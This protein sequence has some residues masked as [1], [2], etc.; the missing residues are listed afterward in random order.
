MEMVKGNKK[1]III[2]CVIFLVFVGVYGYNE[3]IKYRNEKI[4]QDVI[5]SNETV[6]EGLYSD[7]ENADGHDSRID[8]L[9]KAISTRDEYIKNSKTDEDED[10]TAENKYY[11]EVTDG[12]NAYIVEMQDYLISEYTTTIENNT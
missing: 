6:A 11:E 12:Y 4:R 10:V 3:Y 1:R 8:I 2:I 5:S 9:S 7:F